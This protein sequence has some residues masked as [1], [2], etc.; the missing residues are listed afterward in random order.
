[1]LRGTGKHRSASR[2]VGQRHSACSFHWSMG[3]LCLTKRNLLPKSAF[4]FRNAEPSYILAVLHSRLPS[5]F[6]EISPISFITML[7]FTA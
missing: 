2:P 5:G 6:L 7:G 1:M 4:R 3:L